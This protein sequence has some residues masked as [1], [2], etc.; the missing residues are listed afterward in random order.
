MKVDAQSLRELADGIARQYSGWDNPPA[1]GLFV[2]ADG[3]H[4]VALRRVQ[5]AADTDVAGL[6]TDFARIAPTMAAAVQALLLCFEVALGGPENTTEEATRTAVDGIP[7]DSGLR[8]AV[9]VYVMDRS[10][11]LWAATKYRDTG[12]LVTSHHRAGDPY[13]LPLAD[14][15][16]Y[17]ATIL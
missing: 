9:Y 17:A 14:Q 5:I 6:F 2:P 1:V 15:M 8:D 13:P 4:T 12:E 7:S 11:N 3:G 10:G 16:F